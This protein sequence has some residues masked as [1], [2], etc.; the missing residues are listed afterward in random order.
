MNNRSWIHFSCLIILLWISAAL[1]QTTHTVIVAPDGSFAFSPSNLT[2]KIGDTVRWQWAASNHSTTS[3]AS[4]AESWDSGVQNSGFVFTRVFN[5]VGSF[6]YH[7]TPHQNFGM[8]GK[9]IVEAVSALPEDEAIINRN[10]QLDQ[11]YP[12]PFNPTTI[13]RYSVGSNYDSPLHVELGIYSLTGQKVVTLVSENQQAGTYNVQW[14]ATNFASGV[15]FYTLE[16]STGFKRS[17]KL[18]LL[19]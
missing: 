17:R 5:N 7:C 4:S 14:D 10:F 11:N 8:T 18:V 6:P 2:V 3:D 13:I 16:T 1:S 15:Y 9:I 19:R 12:N